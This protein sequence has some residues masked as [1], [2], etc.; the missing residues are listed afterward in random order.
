M[1]M[2]M[3]RGSLALFIIGVVVV[4]A[5]AVGLFRAVRE[6]WRAEHPP[7]QRPLPAPPPPPRVDPPPKPLDRP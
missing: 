5:V 1:W 7:R 3:D 4:I 6:Q 2:L